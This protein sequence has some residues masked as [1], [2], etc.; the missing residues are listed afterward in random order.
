[1]NNKKQLSKETK[2]LCGMAM[3]VA[4][5]VAVSF[6]TMGIKVGHL[7]FDAKDAIITIAAYIYGPIPGVLM[8]F[9]SAS[10]ESIISGFQT[11]PIGWLMDIIS[12]ATFDFSA[13]MIYRH[14]RSFSGALISLGGASVILVAAMMLFNMIISPLF[15]PGMKPFDPA[16]M[17]DIPRLY[18]PFNI[19][20]AL[21]NSAIV[22]YLYKPATFALSKAKLLDA[23]E[24]TPFTFNKKSVVIII[25]GLVGII[26]SIGIFL[27]TYFLN[28]K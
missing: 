21:L 22:M 4:L 28:K 16:I 15:F 26:A 2:N 19:A 10:I 12:S 24:K 27:L 20:K 18:L 13:A 8:S 3:F 1:M 6:L 25:C 11:G 5:S 9:I 14:K 17:V 23:E 7:T